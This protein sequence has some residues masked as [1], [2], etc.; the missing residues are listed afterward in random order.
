MR[1]LR[2]SS[3]LAVILCLIANT[4]F[5]QIQVDADY[6]QYSPVEYSLSVPSQ[7]AQAIWELK[8]LD[9]Q[10]EYASRPYKRDG[11]DVYAFWGQPG[12]YSLEATVVIVDFDNKTFEIKRYNAVF[13]IAGN[14]PTPPPPGPGPGPG[15]GPV[16]PVPPGPSPVPNDEFNN[17]GQR[18][19][20]LCDQIGLQVDLRNR[21][22]EVY[23]TT[24]SMM[25]QPGKFI[26]LSD[27]RTYLEG[28]LRKL[29]LDSSWDKTVILLQED[30][31]ARA[32]MSW[33]AAYNWY[34]AAAA[35]YRGGPLE[36]HPAVWHKP[37]T[38]SMDGFIVTHPA[39]PIQATDLC[40]TGTCNV[41]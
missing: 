20:S 34:R 35:G 41:R 12:R 8:P 33:E 7:N 38:V 28:E 32:P 13:R 30:A 26:K 37:N 11:Q 15:P 2:F 19:D 23:T 22:S 4:L 6:A 40:P 10:T 25:T 1:I 18:L 21:V 16:P 24:A 36:I 3:V 5:G 39:E 14:T 9:G 31:K 27:V 29:S 17:L